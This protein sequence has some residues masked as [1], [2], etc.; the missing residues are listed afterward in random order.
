[1]KKTSSLSSGFDVTELTTLSHE[2]L[3]SQPKVRYYFFDH[4]FHLCF[5]QQS[6]SIF[7]SP[8]ITRYRSLPSV[9]PC[10]HHHNISLSPDPWV[11]FHRALCLDL[12]PLSQSTIMWQLKLLCY[13]CKVKVIILHPDSLNRDVVTGPLS[14]IVRPCASEAVKPLRRE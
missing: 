7:N 3:L 14:N 2:L 13:L 12:L 10:D 9:S 6:Q 5:C 8:P 11:E 1:M 4:F